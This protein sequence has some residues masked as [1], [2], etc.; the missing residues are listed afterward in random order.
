MRTGHLKC[1]LISVSLAFIMMFSV[2]GITAVH[3]FEEWVPTLPPWPDTVRLEPI[4]IGENAY[5]K[6]AMTFPNGGYDVNWGSVTRID[7]VTFSA[8]AEMWVW[9]GPVIM[10]IIDES[11]VYNLG[12]LPPDI[13]EF[14]FKT[15]GIPIKSLQFAHSPELNDT[16][17]LE[18]LYRVSLDLDFWL[19]NGSKLVVKFYS[20]GGGPQGENVAWS[21][22]TPDNVSFSKVVPHPQGRPVE[23]ARLVLTTDNTENVISTVASFTVL[24]AHLE[25]RFTEIPLEWALAS[26]EEKV[27]LETEFSEVPLYW[28]LAPS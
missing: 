1:R 16:L 18:A 22:T 17:K 24:K 12:A 14:T 28:A 23:K 10:V 25:V 15:W 13:Y 19:D 9:T 2:L 26:L 3:S 6:V 5:V 7:S 4:S 27:E 11:H 8:D 20:W 21:G